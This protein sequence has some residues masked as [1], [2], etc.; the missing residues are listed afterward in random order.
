MYE[1]DNNQYDDDT[2]NPVNQY[3][4]LD[5]EKMKTLPG[6]FRRVRRGIVEECC[7]KPC[8]LETLSLYCPYRSEF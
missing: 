5:T 6:Q 1:E 4:L 2:L 3:N 8:S 7:K